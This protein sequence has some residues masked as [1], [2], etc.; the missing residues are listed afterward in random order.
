MKELIVIL[1][2]AGLIFWLAKPIALR[3]TPNADFLRR[4][5]VWF[6]LTITAFLSPNFWIFALFAVP[7]YVWMGRK[8]S[9]PIAAY[10]L[11]MHVVPPVSV[12]LPAIGGSQLFSLDNYRLL[13]FCVL[14]PLALQARRSLPRALASRSRMADLLLLAFVAL[15]SATFV[16]PDLPNHVILHDSLTN[17]LRRVLLD[18]I[19]ILV[20][21]YAVS[22]SCNDRNKIVDVQAAFCVSST[23][24][25]V[26][27]IFEHFRGWLL[28]TQLAAHWDPTDATYALAWLLRG[29]SWLRAQASSGHALSLA[30]MLAVAFGF[31]LYLQP[32]AATLRARLGVVIV[33]WLGMVATFSRGPWI[34]AVLIYLA[35]SALKPRA[36][37]RLFKAGFLMAIVLGLVSLSPIGEKMMTSLH[38]TGG[39]PDADFIYRQRLLDRSLELVQAHPLFGDPLAMQE[40][41]DLRQGQ[42]IID[43]V[44]TYVGV[45]LFHGWIGLVLFLGFILRALTGVVRAAKA[46]ISTDPDWAL[47]GFNI[48]ACIIGILFMI[49]DCSLTFGIEKMFYVLIAL[50][51]AYASQAKQ[52]IS[53]ACTTDTDRRNEPRP[54]SGVSRIVPNRTVR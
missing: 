21:Y 14:I 3:F 47:L 22:R 8:D 15:S 46:A 23:I 53:T 1:A 44:N 33:F 30:V 9:N 39:Q 20:L 36:I 49:A 37:S 5:N 41:E 43:I 16:P 29:D 45:L 27:A 18:F 40:M 51:V 24:M 4:R 31:W 10:L 19:D 42:G 13:S 54:L 35:Y 52:A 12:D 25:A 28:Y 26:V 48:A 32:R 34:G 11:L 50:A 7:I 17:L 6:A 2:I 38:V